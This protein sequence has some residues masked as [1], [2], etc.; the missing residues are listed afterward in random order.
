MSIAPDETTGEV[1][2]RMKE[3]GANVVLE[4]LKQ[5][6]G[7]TVQAIPQDDS[8]ATSAPKI[9]RDDCRIPWARS[10]NEVHNFIRGLSPHPGA[11]TCYGDTELKI[12]RSRISGETR[13]EMI[14]GSVVCTARVLQVVCSDGVIT[15]LELQQ[16]GKRRMPT[17]AF[18]QGFQIH[19][20]EVLA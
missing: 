5:I 1:H 10:C 3:L 13:T 2:D 20:G 7:G 18:L 19:T 4:T 14:P 16:Q 6:L 17:E 8:N 12:F 9:F 11:W 15:V